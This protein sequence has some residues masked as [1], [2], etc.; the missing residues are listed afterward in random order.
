PRPFQTPSPA[1]PCEGVAEESYSTS[2]S[3]VVPLPWP[4]PPPTQDSVPT[5][6]SAK[7]NSSEEVSLSY[8]QVRGRVTIAAQDSVHRRSGLKELIYSSKTKL[9][10]RPCLRACLPACLP[11]CLPACLPGCVHNWGCVMWLLDR[12]S[13]S[14]VPAKRS[15]FD[16]LQSPSADKD[17]KPD[18]LQSL[19]NSAHKDLK[20]VQLK[21]RPSA[22]RPWSPKAAEKEKSATQNELERS[23]SKSSKTLTAP[24]HTAAPLAPPVHPRDS[25]TPG[26]GP[27]AISR[28]PQELHN[29]DAQP[30]A[31][32][33]PSCT[34]DQPEDMDT[35]GEIDVGDCDDREYLPFLTIQRNT[36]PVS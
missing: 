17:R 34:A 23:Y 2:A 30:A 22:F 12:Q 11:G 33:P 5:G 18:W 28:L 16:E 9:C 3:S 20:K 19:S 14:P 10:E 35:D 26:K 36:T 15:K 7:A 4:N 25:H 21:Q 8:Q 24:N 32:M 29:G 27:A 1:L 31:K 6:D 13:P